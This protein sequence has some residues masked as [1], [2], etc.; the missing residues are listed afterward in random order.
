MFYYLL[1]GK[2]NRTTIRI[3]KYERLIQ[4]GRDE[5]DAN[6]VT[7]IVFYYTS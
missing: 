3:V 4:K 1:K 5:Y 7:T 6:S 2:M